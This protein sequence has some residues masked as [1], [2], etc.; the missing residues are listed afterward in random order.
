MLGRPDPSA[1][2][3]SSHRRRHRRTMGWLRYRKTGDAAMSSRVVAFIFARGGSKGLP[4]KNLRLLAGKPL[5][6]HAIDVAKA[7]PGIARVVVST[8]DPMIA[9]AARGAGAEVPFLRPAG[10]ATDTAPE[11]LAWQHAI[12]ALREEGDPVEVFLSLPTTA[13]LRRP[14]DVA[15]CIDT[16]ASGDADIVI[17]VREAERNP[18]FNMVRRETDGSVRLAVEGVYHRRQDAPPIFDITTVA[19]AARADFILSANRIFDGRVR[20][21]VIPRERALDIDDAFDLAVAEALYDRISDFPDPCL[22]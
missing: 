16:L 20:A 12:R 11:W 15:C 1:R 2:G 5:L 7:V 9:E 17:T 6:T 3:S 4:G 18:Y 19:Y 14:V 22:L 21:I 8:D 13:P 10:L